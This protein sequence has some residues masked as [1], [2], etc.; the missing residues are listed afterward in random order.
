MDAD[1]SEICQVC[2]NKS[3]T[4]LTAIL[5]SFNTIIIQLI[6]S[7]EKYVDCT[8][9]MYSGE[10]EETRRVLSPSELVLHS[11]Y[12]NES[13]RRAT[14]FGSGGFCEVNTIIK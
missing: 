13:G 9:V 4:C 5:S 14:H 8:D 6:I 1:M 12:H 10:S 7:Q 11:A 3:K 2:L